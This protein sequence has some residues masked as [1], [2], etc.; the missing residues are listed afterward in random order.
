M[1][2]ARLPPS[3][4]VSA[5]LGQSQNVRARSHTHTH[6]WSMTSFDM[7]ARGDLAACGIT[8]C[9]GGRVKGDSARGRGA[10]LKHRLPMPH[11]RLPAQA[12]YLHQNR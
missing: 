10:L 11:C 4:Q 1:L 3:K 2:R 9:R 5:P 8:R 7:T 6:T 12:R